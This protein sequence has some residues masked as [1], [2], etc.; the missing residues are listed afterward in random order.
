MKYEN[1]KIYFF[2]KNQNTCVKKG[3]LNPLSKDTQKNTNMH[4]QGS[5]GPQLEEAI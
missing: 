5:K 1:T 4:Q 3:L 2:I